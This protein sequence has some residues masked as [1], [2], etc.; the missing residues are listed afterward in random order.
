M[1]GRAA[2][3]IMRATDRIFFNPVGDTSG[4]AEADWK[5][6]ITSDTA[7]RIRIRNR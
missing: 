5:V 4:R 7:I 6:R 1:S 3:G 2:A